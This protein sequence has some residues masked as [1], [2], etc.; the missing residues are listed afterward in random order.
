MGSIGPFPGWLVAVGFIVVIDW[1]IMQVDPHGAYVFAFLILASVLVLRPNAVPAIV[2]TLGA[3]L[4][5]HAGGPATAD[6]RGAP[7][8]TGAP[9]QA[10]G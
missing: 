7:A 9:V 8:N 4:G 1:G 2:E 6:N 10:V 3:L 5:S